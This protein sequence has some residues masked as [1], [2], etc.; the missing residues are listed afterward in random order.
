MLT[1]KFALAKRWSIAGDNDEFGLAGSEGFQSR[2][3]AQSD[4]LIPVKESVPV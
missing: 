4:C 2:F 1:F 3:V